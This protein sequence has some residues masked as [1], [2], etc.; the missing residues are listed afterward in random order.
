MRG[1][2]G[3]EVPVPQPVE[4]TMSAE[5]KAAEEKRLAEEKKKA[6]AEAKVKAE[7][8]G[9]T[10][11]MNV[12]WKMTVI[13][14]EKTVAKSIGY[15]LKD[16]S[17]SQ[18]GRQKRAAG[19]ADLGRYYVAAAE[20]TGDIRERY[21]EAMAATA[22]G[23]GT[24]FG[25][26]GGDE[27]GEWGAEGDAAPEGGIPVGAV[28]QVQGLVN[29][30]QHNGKVGVVR[31]YDA[32]KGRYILQLQSGESMKIKGDNLAPAPADAAGGFAQPSVEEVE[33]AKQ[34]CPTCL[35]AS[36]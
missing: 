1:D 32:E 31:G 20:A 14:V 3:T 4:R 6:E 10:K 22:S 23:D 26:G 11:M 12:M 7:Q 25:F 34:P 16:E 30:A 9:A 36:H 35:S 13:D 33:Y 19:I 21:L 27:P 24:P 5:E 15:V 2:D 8:E 28:V 29:A 18:D 17:I